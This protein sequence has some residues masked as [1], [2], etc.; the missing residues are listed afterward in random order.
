MP[1]VTETV[2]ACGALTCPSAR[3]GNVMLC[4][5]VLSC[6]GPT[7]VPESGT[8]T[9]ATPLVVELTVRKPLRPPI[10]M[11]AKTIEAVQLA[12]AASDCVQ[13]FD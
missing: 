13:P 11:G 2:M 4:I 1:P 9:E 3:F 7:A 10:T 8:M 12:P 5:E 6:A